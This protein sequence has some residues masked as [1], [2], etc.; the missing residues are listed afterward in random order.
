MA[1]NSS[2]Q[3]ASGRNPLETIRSTVL[4]LDAASIR[5]S[6]AKK[7]PSALSA[8]RNEKCCS[9]SYASIVDC[10]TKLPMVVRTDL[11]PGST[12]VAPMNHELRPGPVAIASHTVSGGRSK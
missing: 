9:G 10:C 5:N 7:R 4:P 11:S 8:P 2:S 3:S 6:I 12:S 1:S